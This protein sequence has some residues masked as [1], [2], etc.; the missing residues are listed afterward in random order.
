MLVP[1]KIQHVLCTG[2]LCSSAVESYLRSI[3]PDVSIV[4]G[5]MDVS[6]SYFFVGYS[7]FL[8]SVLANR[9]LQNTSP[10]ARLRAL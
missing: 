1:G 5:D 7:L 4:A 9:V 2:N 8:L 10:N 3:S 6:V